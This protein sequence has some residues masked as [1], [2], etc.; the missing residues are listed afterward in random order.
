MSFDPRYPPTTNSLNRLRLELASPALLPDD[1][2][3][4]TGYELLSTRALNHLIED[5]IQ[6]HSLA[7][8]ELPDDRMAWFYERVKTDSDLSAT[9]G[10]TIGDRLGC[11]LLTL[12]QNDEG[13]R[14]ANLDKAAAYWDY[15]SDVRDI[16]LGGGLLSG[17]FGQRVADQ[18][19]ALLRHRQALAN[20][21]VT[22]AGHPQ[23][24]PI[25]GA[26]RIVPSGRRAAGFDFGGTFVKR[27]LATYGDV[28]LQSVRLLD[29]VSAEFSHRTVETPEEAR[30]IFERMVDIIA[31]T[32]RETNADADTIPVCIASYVDEHGQ[33]LV[34]QRGIYMNL[35]R[36]TGDVGGA[37]S[38]AVSDRLGQP[39]TIRLLHDG[40]AAA[41]YYAPRQHAAVLMIGTALGSGYPVPRPNLALRSVV[42]PLRVG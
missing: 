27:A 16:F 10:I 21:T 29:T 4:K 41:L 25:L 14:H 23:H 15:W 36:L 5:Y 28:G 9:I 11:L 22:L 24:L 33:P 18:A 12:M 3:G 7:V 30:P 32:Y 37:L 2:D 35:A 8:P 26:A 39:V 17:G 20:A 40:T 13:T 19:Q 1:I 31:Q 42:S 34:T 6:A 38:Q